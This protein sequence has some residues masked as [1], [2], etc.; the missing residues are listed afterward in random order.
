M[1][2]IELEDLIKFSK[3][4]RVLYVEDNE[5]LRQDSIGIFKI[6]FHN[7]DIASDGIEGFKY[8][9]NNKYDLIITAIDMPNMNGVHMISRIRNISKNITI[10]ITSSDTK[11]FIELIKLGIDGYILKPVEVKQFTSIVQKVIEKLQN[12]QELY[13]YKNHLKDIVKNKTKE[14]EFLNLNLDKRVKEEILKNKIK[15]HLITTQSKMASMGEMIENI[16][17]QW[18]QPLSV[19]S[20]ASS[21]MQLQ[22]EHNILTDDLFNASCNAINKNAQYL[23]KTIDNFQNFIKGDRT[24]IIFNLKDNIDIFLNLIDNLIKSN[25]INIVLDL[26]KDIKINGYKNE[27]TQCLMNIFNNAKDILKEKNIKNKYIFISTTI[28]DKKAIIKIK[29]NAG[30][31]PEDIINKIFEP[32]FTT[33]H[34]SQGTG[35]GLNMTYNLVVDGMNGTIEANNVDYKYDS[36]DYT[37]AEFVISLPIE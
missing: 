37:G 6:F 26:Q 32:Y 35:L 17:H 14:L 21:G 13:E 23:S 24:K 22:K 33:K 18:R 34:K 5:K 11:N 3:T 9:E 29:D 28:Q 31:I 19:I 2:K 12:K 25:N 15:D 4:I 20:T 7:I 8:F 30:G 10:L 36:K 27:L 16:A 1:K